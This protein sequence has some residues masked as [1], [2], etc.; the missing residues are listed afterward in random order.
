MVHLLFRIDI[1][2]D[3]E[4]G[5]AALLQDPRNQRQKGIRGNS[6]RQLLRRVHE[7]VALEEQKMR[8]FPLEHERDAQKSIITPGDG[9]PFFGQ[10]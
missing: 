2:F 8:R 4:R 3:P 6:I 7:E 10:I 5:Y 9:D 1:G